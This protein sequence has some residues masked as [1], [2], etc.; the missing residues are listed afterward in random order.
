MRPARGVTLIELLV[1]GAVAVL[2]LSAAGLVVVSSASR[3]RRELERANLERHSLLLLEQLT[4]ELRQAGLGVPSGQNPELAG[5]RF[6]SIFLRGD[7]AEVVFLAD[8]PR[9]NSSFN[10]VSQLSD[11]QQATVPT[12]GV[13]VLNELSGP[14]DVDLTGPHCQT[15]QVSALFPPSTGCASNPAAPTCPWALNRYQPNEWV[16]LANGAGRWLER[17]VGNPVHGA[18]ADRR[19]LALQVA[20]PAGFFAGF[21]NRGFVS[22]PDRVFYRLNGTAVERNQCWGQIGAGVTVAALATACAAGPDG[23]GWEVLAEGATSPGLAFEYRDGADNPI[24]AP[25][26]AAALPLI[27]RVVVRVTLERA[28][29]PGATAIRTDSSTSA[30]VRL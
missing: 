9:P 25:V 14:C 12:S 19:Y 28:P 30:S 10:G 7:P 20:R 5:A 26:P 13:V 29:G 6:P 17:Q 2:V 24:A 1:G 27:R 15:D 23:T 16:L 8:L 22:S 4:A 11:E 3:H 21:P 18:S